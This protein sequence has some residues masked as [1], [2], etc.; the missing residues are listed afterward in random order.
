MLICQNMLYLL[1]QVL[2]YNIAKNWIHLALISTMYIR[3]KQENEL[4]I[5]VAVMKGKKRNIVAVV[6]VQYMQFIKNV[7]QHKLSLNGSSKHY[8]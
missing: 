8:N 7:K 1:F 5:V 3:G 6:A 4:S 2:Q